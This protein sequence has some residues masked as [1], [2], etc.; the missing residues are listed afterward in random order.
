MINT[1]IFSSRHRM[2]KFKSIWRTT[3]PN[4]TI[5]LPVIAPYVIDWGDGIET[6]TE[7][8]H[9]YA[10]AGDYTIKITGVITDFV[11]NNSGDKL[12][13]LEVQQFGGMTE[14]KSASFF[15]CS[16]LDITAEE[17]LN[18]GISLLNAFNGNSSLVYNPSINL[19]DTSLTQNMIGVF[20]GDSLFNNS[21]GNWVLSACITISAILRETSIFN[22]NLDSWDVSNVTDTSSAFQSSFLFNSPLNSWVTSSFVLCTAMFRAAF[23]FNQPLFNWDVSNVENMS[24]MFDQAFDFDQ[25]LSSWDFSSV[26]NMSN[27]MKS[28]SA[29]NYSTTNMDALLNRLDDATFGLNFAIA[30]NVN[31]SFGSINYTSAGSAALASL[32][33]KGYVISIGVQ[34]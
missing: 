12:K 11:F 6:S 10:I 21:I 4:E 28:K 26:K 32:V 19:L 15:G 24:L 22:Q 16:N 25:D 17:K 13:I 7:T 18:A 30:T 1:G 31:V 9:E 14:I 27:F 29:A 3:G 33:S 23:D 2:S 20:Q 8:S 5:Q 34:V